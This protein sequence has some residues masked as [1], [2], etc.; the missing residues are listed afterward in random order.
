MRDEMKIMLAEWIHGGRLEHISKFEEADFPGYERL[1]AA[2]AE[3]HGNYKKIEPV[4]LAHS[5]G[6]QIAD[7][8]EITSS[9]QPGFYQGAYRAVKRMRLERLVMDAPRAKD[10]AAYSEKI[11][12]ELSNLDVEDEIQPDNWTL[13]LIT[14]IERRGVEKPLPY[15]IESLDYLMGGV[16]KR[17]LT[18]IAARPSVGKTALASQIA[19]NIADTGHKVMYL[20]LEMDG[21]QMAERQAL[22]ISDG[23]SQDHLRSGNLSNEEW[24]KLS[25]VID[26]LSKRQKNLLM[27]SGL[28]YLPDI[29]RTIKKE[30]PEVVFIDQLSQLR[31]YQSFKSIRDRFTYLTNRLKEIAMETGVP[32]ILLCQINR[33]AEDIL[34]TLANLKESGSIE[35]DADN[36]LMIHRLTQEQAEDSKAFEPIQKL[37]EEELRPMLIRIQ[38]QRNGK[39]GD[40]PM[41]YKGKE[42]KFLAV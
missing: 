31:T 32:I 42:F 2:I 37:T 41:L 21:K 5:A 7:V 25:P 35:E 8:V 33:G 1:F 22:Q 17:E 39:T 12:G 38:K 3:Q 20:P 13:D 9:Y 19:C 16:R 36:V 15:G 28:R 11:V 23:V 40:I 4:S 24:N 34:P 18:V 26:V 30:L 27:F 6:M 14:E 10:I 29:E